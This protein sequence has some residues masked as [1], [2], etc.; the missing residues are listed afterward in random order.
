MGWQTYQTTE[1]DWQMHPSRMQILQVLHSDPCYRG[2]LQ[3]FSLTACPMIIQPPPGLLYAWLIFWINKLINAVAD[4][5]MFSI[6]RS[7]F[8]CF[9]ML[10][11]VF[12][13][14]ILNHSASIIALLTCHH[15][16]LFP[17]NVSACMEC[18]K[19]IKTLLDIYQQLC[20]TVR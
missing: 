15:R 10:A 9:G 12:L 11:A 2:I 6:F 19:M 16:P 18:I 1:T 4:L 7:T 14:S 17:N 3:S 5:Y 20:S 13:L 8:S